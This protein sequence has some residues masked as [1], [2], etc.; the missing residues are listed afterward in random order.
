MSGIN[1]KSKGM[2]IGPGGALLELEDTTF[3]QELAFCSY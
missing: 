1:E 3:T 2:Y